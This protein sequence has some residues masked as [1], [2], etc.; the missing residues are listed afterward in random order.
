MIKTLKHLR[1][2][3]EY[4]FFLLYRRFLLILGL[5]RAANICSFFARKIGPALKVSKIAKNN[6]KTTIG[7]DLSDKKLNQL[8]DQ[9]WDHFGR[10]IAEFVYTPELSTEEINQYVKIEGL[11]NA[12]KF[13]NAGKPFLLCLAHVGNWDFLIR[14]ITALY[15]KFTI[16]YRKANNPYVDKAIIDSR[17]TEGVN[18]VAKGNAG[19]KD[20]IR[21]IKSGSAIA[22]LVDQK[23][24]DGIEVP[25]MGKPAM[26]ANAIAKL[27]LQFDMPIV[28]AQIVRVNGSHFKAIIY[29]ELKYNISGDKEKDSYDIMLQINQI[30]EGWIRQHPEQWFW[31][32]NRWKK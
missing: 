24:N 10:Y 5:E 20:L 4:A 29:P 11:E 2:L 31:F 7:K 28:P 25:F 32:H 21:A 16:I 17:T 27:S 9:L 13:V 3:L 18:L 12:Q 30:I 22:M 1:H 19:A 8:I 26:T 14:N 6:I 15:P 23:M